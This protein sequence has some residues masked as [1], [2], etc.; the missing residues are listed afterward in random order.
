VVKPPLTPVCLLLLACAGNPKGPTQPASDQS[1]T[2]DLP[3]P[4][5]LAPA[6]QEA[7]S[8]GRQLYVIDKIS[9][10]GTDVLLENVPR[11]QEHGLAGYLTVQDGDDSGQPKKSF[12]VMFYTGG[13]EP[14]VAFEIHVAPETKPRFEAVSPPRRASP[15]MQELIRARKTA[16]DALPEHNQPINPVLLP[17]PVGQEVV[18][19]LLAGTK[20]PGIAVFGKHHRAR[21]S[22]DGRTLIKLEPLSKSILELPL[23]LPEGTTEAGLGITHIISETPNATHVFVSLLH[24]LPVYVGTSRG[25]WR[26]DGERIAYVKDS[27]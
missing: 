26:V 15:T 23:K 19:Y 24:K 9:A 3:I 2:N 12:T 22:A 25:L 10:I 17:G 18:V 1:V 21:V 6:I 11:P 4:A 14:K 20:Q 8:V 7:E 27:R 5:D 16:I 13:P